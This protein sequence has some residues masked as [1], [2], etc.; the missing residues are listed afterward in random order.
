MYYETKKDN[1]VSGVREISNFLGIGVRIGLRICQERPNDCPIIR[2]G[3]RY[4][5]DKALLTQ[6][7]NDWYLGKFTIEI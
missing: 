3:N 6:W 1:F 2:L 4:Q 5:A 7:K